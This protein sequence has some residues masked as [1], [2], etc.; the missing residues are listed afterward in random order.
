MKPGLVASLALSISG[1]PPA[2]AGDDI[3]VMTQNQYLGA[4]FS[5]LLAPPGGDFN[6]ALVRILQQIAATDFPARAERQA[7]EIA[8]R[9]P[10]L[11]GLQEAWDLS[12]A[13]LDPLDEEGC[14]NPA[15]ADAFVNYLDETL[16]A[17]ARAV[18]ITL[19]SLSSRTWT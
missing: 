19:T 12:C 11:V 5:S 7:R 14:E 3:V 4:D 16:D 17:L 10:H 13:D 8:R 2:L 15:I 9:N 18:R 1:S 6:A